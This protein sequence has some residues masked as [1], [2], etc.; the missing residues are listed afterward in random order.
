LKIAGQ[1]FHIRT[2]SLREHAPV[3]LHGHRNIAQQRSVDCSC[4]RN[5]QTGERC[6]FFFLRR[7]GDAVWEAGNS[8]RQAG[9]EPEP[10]AAVPF[11]TRRNEDDSC[12]TVARRLTFLVTC[13]NMRARCA[14]V[15]VWMPPD[16]RHWS[17]SIP[18]PLTRHASA[19]T[20]ATAFMMCSA[21][22]LLVRPSQ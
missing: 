10:E 17:P 20:P 14:R 1:R 16:H 13:L 12:G 9:R 19:T 15:N 4:L 3:F 21:L 2:D 18:F 5:L 7:L 8:R 11:E 22:L 6:L